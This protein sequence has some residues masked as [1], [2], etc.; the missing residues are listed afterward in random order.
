MSDVPGATGSLAGRRL[1]VTGASRGIGRAI[2]LR[3]ARD[4]AAVALAAKTVVPRPDLPG[5]IHDAARDV[6]RAGGRA[7]ALELDVRDAERFEAAIDEAAR[8]L[9]GLDVVV[10]GAGAIDLAGTRDTPVKR[11]DLMHAVNARAMWVGTRAAIPHL[12]RSDNAHVLALAPPLDLDPRWLGPHLAYSLSKYGM[13][14]CVLGL[15]EELREAGIAVDGLWPRTVIATAALR[16]LGGRVRPAECRTPEIVA[17]A[18]HAILV[19]DAR[20]STGRMWIDE[21][22]LREAGVTDFERYAVEAGSAL[23]DDLFIGEPPS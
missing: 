13:S 17:D 10:H 19:S 8:A 11:F 12:E 2:A 5:T 23:V 14:L 4:G 18:A 20:R 21:E 16:R 22:V 1:F 6:E 3:A 15:A 7:V 9:G